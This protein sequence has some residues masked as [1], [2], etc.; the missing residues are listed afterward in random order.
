MFTII[1]LGL[2]DKSQRETENFD[3]K[4]S[5]APKNNI[6]HRG[7]HVAEIKTSPFDPKNVLF[8]KISG[9]VNGGF[10]QSN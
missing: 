2:L 9:E 5:E 1:T 6:K 4:Q 10:K 8:I 7:D 3:N